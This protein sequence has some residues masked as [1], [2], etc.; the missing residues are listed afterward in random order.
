MSGIE[1]AGG[2]GGA[3]AVL[4]LRQRILER[5]AALQQA[6][7]P[8]QPA[9]PAGADPFTE[10]MARAIA[11]VNA[12]QS[13]SSAASAAYERGET[14]DIASVMLARQKA[15]LAFEATLQARNRLLSAYR[16][17]MNMPI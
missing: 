7:A 3:A 15:S 4:A 17:I 11:Q 8:A 5:S 13:A 14:Q 9:R 16:D 10:A 2:L 6:L 12:L 1:A